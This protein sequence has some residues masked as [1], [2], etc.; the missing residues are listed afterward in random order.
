[1]ETIPRI[2]ILLTL[3][4]TAMGHRGRKSHSP[5][6]LVTRRQSANVFL[7]PLTL[8]QDP[9]PAVYPSNAVL[10]GIRLHGF[11]SRPRLLLFFPLLSS[12]LSSRSSKNGVHYPPARSTLV[13]AFKST[14]RYLPAGNA[15][16]GFR[17]RATRYRKASKSPVRCRYTCR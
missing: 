10:P 1:M 2:R 3:R 4:R 15:N 12:I 11:L 5:V 6:K 7:I 14:V 9:L 8:S 13:Y 16:Q 17:T